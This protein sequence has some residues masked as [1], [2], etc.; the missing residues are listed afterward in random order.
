MSVT[1]KSLD[2]RSFAIV[3]FWQGEG[4]GGGGWGTFYLAKSFQLAIPETDFPC[5]FLPKNQFRPFALN[6]GH[7]L[8]NLHDW[9]N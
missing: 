7:H 1:A 8:I 4:G 6:R 9:L 3:L 5:P 2:L